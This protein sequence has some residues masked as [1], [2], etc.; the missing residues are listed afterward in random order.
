MGSDDSST[1]LVRRSHQAFNDRDREA[2][3]GSLAEDVV[4]HVAGEH[5]LAGTYAG[6]AALWEGFMDPMWASPARVED[7]DVFEH[8]DH[9]VAVGD[10]I[11]DFGEGQA[12]F[13]TVEVFRVDGGRLAERWEFTSRQAE[14]DRFL[15]RGCAAAAGLDPD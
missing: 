5:P 14:L 2:F 7:R 13:A 1:G 15:T 12:R 4:W 10:A 3:L 9:V 8:G 6:R 11:H